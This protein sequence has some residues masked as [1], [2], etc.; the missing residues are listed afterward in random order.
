MML[1][2][3]FLGKINQGAVHSMESYRLRSFV[4]ILGVIFTIVW[5]LP[6]IVNV[7]D[8]KWWPV[9]SKLNYGLDIQGGVNLVMGV[10]VQGVVSETTLR[11]ANSMRA[12]FEKENIAGLEI[13][14]P[15]PHLGEIQVSFANA[16]DKVKVEKYLTDFHGTTLQTMSTKM[17]I[18]GTQLRY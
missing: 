9:K 8:V 17:T 6:N 11:L 16:A 2:R 7:Q 18:L 3:Y 4:A 12:E 1:G 15:A 14:T 10:D 5:V 13:K